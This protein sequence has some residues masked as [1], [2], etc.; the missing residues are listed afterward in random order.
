MTVVSIFLMVVVLILAALLYLE[1]GM[2]RVSVLDRRDRRYEELA[3]LN[4]QAE[5]GQTVFFGDSITQYCPVEE[6]Y[7]SYIASSGQQ[8]YNR[9]IASETT[10]DAIKR[11]D[12]NVLS[13]NPGTLVILYGCNDI[14]QKIP[15]S[16]TVANMEEIIVRVRKKNPDVHIIMQAV[17]PVREQ[18]N[19]LPAK[20]LIGRRTCEKIKQLNIALEELAKRM[21]ISFVN[22]TDILADESGQLRTEYTADGLHVNEIAYRQIA[23]EM[24]PMLE[25]GKEQ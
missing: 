20:L 13:I 15:V 2:F 3:F 24:I 22:L 21:G 18:G 9:G 10:Q 7:A 8:V 1:F 11:L 12:S 16:R 4:K 19:G 5:S 17:Y 23:A 14:G 6:I 25:R